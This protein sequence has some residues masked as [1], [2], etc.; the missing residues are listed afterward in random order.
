MLPSIS[1]VLIW[2][3][4]LGLPTGLGDAATHTKGLGKVYTPEE[5]AI[6]PLLDRATLQTGKDKVKPSL[7]RTSRLSGHRIA[8]FTVHVERDTVQCARLDGGKIHWTTKTPDGVKLIWLGA[9]DNVLYFAAQEPGK[10]DLPVQVRRLG[11]RSGKWLEDL[12]L[13]PIRGGKQETIQALIAGGENIVLLTHAT[14]ISDEERMTLYRVACFK[15]GQVQPVWVKEFNS[16]GGLAP[17]GSLLLNEV[18][19]PHRTRSHHRP[20]SWLGRNILVCAGPVQDL[21]CLE[22]SGGHER[23]RVPRIWEFERGFKGPSDWRHFFIRSSPD[24]ET[25][26]GPNAQK[27]MSSRSVI[28]GGPHVI[29]SEHEDEHVFVAVAKG[30]GRYSEYVSSCVVYELDSAGKPLAMVTLPRMILGHHF[31]AQRDGLVWACEGGAFVRL[32]R[33]RDRDLR[34]NAGPGGP[35]LLCRLD[36]YRHLAN[37]EP[38]S[39]WLTTTVAGDSAA[40]GDGVAFRVC[41]GGYITDKLAGQFSF[42]ISMIDLRS[43]ADRSLLLSVPYKG[44]VADPTANCMYRKLPDGKEHWHSLLPCILTVS[45]LEVV[46]HRLRVTL[47][48]AAHADSLDFELDDLWDSVASRKGKD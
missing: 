46:G 34:D 10:P 21:L 32:A 29:A 3:S 16:A 7:I 45:G 33:S 30:R 44:T 26:K 17:A 28:V 11:L 2:L 38:Q 43:G 37:A 12:Q 6:F 35:D 9:G 22:I 39:A 40:M 15:A 5:N 8:D 27:R 36:W 48:M 24:E 13:A 31:E 20:L 23:W 1:S 14:E 25:T 42:P 41:I 18:N 19:V 4:G 47:R